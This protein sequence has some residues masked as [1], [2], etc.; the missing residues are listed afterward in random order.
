MPC[1]FVLQAA[2]RAHE[3]LL[4]IPGRALLPKLHFLYHSPHAHYTEIVQVVTITNIP[5]LNMSTHIYSY[6][7]VALSNDG[8][9][10]IQHVLVRSKMTY[11]YK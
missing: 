3:A 1:L 4:V 9:I 7:N 11:M 5:E 8:T 10:V 2:L 6:M